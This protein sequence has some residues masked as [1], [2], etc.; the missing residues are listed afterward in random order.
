MRVINER[1]FKS[2]DGT[3]R[4][5]Q[6]GWSTW[7]DNELSVRFY[8]EDKNGRFCRQ[9]PEVPLDCVVYMIALMKENLDVLPK[10]VVILLAKY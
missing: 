6:F 9:S 7:D 2:T 8:Y 10:E 1:T 3:E 5:I 4:R